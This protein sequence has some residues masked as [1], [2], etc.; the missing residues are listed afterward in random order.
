M[1][2]QFMSEIKNIYYVYL[3]ANTATPSSVQQ[4]IT[5]QIR[6]AREFGYNVKG[7]FFN[8]V[9][10]EKCNVED[11]VWF[12]APAINTGYFR[13]I[14]QHARKFAAAPPENRHQ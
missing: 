1:P 12:Q 5:N 9:T 6:I 14:R 10:L 3:T 4:K 8:T 7:L 11:I 2:L 13:S